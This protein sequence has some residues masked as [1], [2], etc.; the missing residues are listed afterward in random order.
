MRA[1]GGD[2]WES[3]CAFSRYNQLSIVRKAESGR[4]TAQGSRRESPGNDKSGLGCDRSFAY[5]NGSVTWKV[6]PG[7]ELAST[8]MRPP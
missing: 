2:A 5:A 6:E 7:T 3:L 4:F 8:Q 1:I